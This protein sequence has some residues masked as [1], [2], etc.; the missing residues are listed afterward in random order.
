MK[1]I[2][3]SITIGS[4]NLADSHC[5]KLQLALIKEEKGVKILEP[6]QKVGIGSYLSSGTILGQV[7]Y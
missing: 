7:R 3:I 4:A 5:R 1:N 2:G 6:R